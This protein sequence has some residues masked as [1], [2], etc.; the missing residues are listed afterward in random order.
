MDRAKS[1]LAPMVAIPLV[2]LLLAGAVWFGYRVGNE[3]RHGEPTARPV[4]WSI[5]PSTWASQDTTAPRCLP[6]SELVRHAARLDPSDHL[7][8]PA[9]A[10]SAV[11]DET[12]SAPPDWSVE[13]VDPRQ[14]SEAPSNIRSEPAVA[15]PTEPGPIG[16]SENRP[17]AHVAPFAADGGAIDGPTT[18]PWA[19]P[20]RP[21]ERSLQLERMAQQ[22]DQHTRRGFELAS[23][24]A[25]HSAG[26]EFIRAARVV[27]QGLDSERATH[28]HSQALSAGLT[29]LSE[30]DDFVP[31]GSQLEGNLDIAGVIIGHATPVLKLADF[32]RLTPLQAVERYMDYAR[33]QLSVAAG[34]EV[35]GSMALHALG[36]LHGSLAEQQ[37]ATQPIAGTKAMVFLQAAVQVCPQNHLAFN[38]LGVLLA[39]GG[40][41]RDAAAAFDRSLAMVRDPTTMNNQAKVFE[42]LGDPARA[43]QVRHEA[44][45]ILAA[46]GKMDRHSARPAPPVVWV[47]PEEFTRSYAA[48]AG[49]WQPAPVKHETATTASPSAAQ[50]PVEQAKRGWSWNPF[51]TRQ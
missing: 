24:K 2:A 27:A 13:L 23:A 6:Q 1:L 25:Y 43:A 50:A 34:G 19:T 49:L 32:Q 38:D 36:K 40:R 21:G 9:D 45:A 10:P 14:P 17:E 44:V 39:G 35:A 5:S 26:A 11:D 42:Q 28:V 29:A 16:V 33:Q 8:N 48:S 7:T 15:G 18:T 31:V 20:Y 37:G 41:Y 22:A 12:S 3:T 30:A 4:S 51:K 47:S 46:R